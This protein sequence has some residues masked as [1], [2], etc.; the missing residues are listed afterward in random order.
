MVHE[1]MRNDL[2]TTVRLQHQ[3]GESRDTKFT[4]FSKVTVQHGLA[5]LASHPL[6]EYMRVDP[7]TA[8]KLAKRIDVRGIARFSIISGLNTIDHRYPKVWAE[9]FCS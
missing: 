2:K 4:N 6:P 5:T 8:G 3:T 7:D 9:K 1:V